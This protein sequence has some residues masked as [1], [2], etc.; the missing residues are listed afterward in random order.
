MSLAVIAV[1]G[2]PSSGKTTHAKDYVEYWQVPFF[3]D[4]SVGKGP[5]DFM[6]FLTDPPQETVMVTDVALCKQA[7]RD[8]FEY[9]VKSLHPLATIKYICFENDPKQCLINAKNRND[10]REVENTIRSM[11]KVYTYPEGAEIIP[12]WKLNG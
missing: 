7:T 5:S 2:L 4:V 9:C 8:D 6:E 12:V 1:I 3:D 11:A 10:G